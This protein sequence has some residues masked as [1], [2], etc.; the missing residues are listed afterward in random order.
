MP[1]R[2]LALMF[3]MLCI[4]GSFTTVSARA[5]DY[6]DS[7][8]VKII[9][10]GNGQI[11][12]MASVNGTHGNMTQIGIPVLALQE[13]NGTQYTTVAIYT[14][15]YKYNALTYGY[16]FT[17]DA[18]VGKEYRALASFMAKDSTGGDT[19]EA[20]SLLVKAK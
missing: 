10:L 6:I 5:S 3:A 18:V 16:Y 1:K 9:T 4:M 15:L 2:I 11:R 8:E 12:V 7:Y 19:R 17:Y 13:K 20:Q 14:S